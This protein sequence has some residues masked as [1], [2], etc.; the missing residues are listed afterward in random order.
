MKKCP[1]C[2]LN[3]ISNNE[4]LCKVCETK[5][6]NIKT[7]S[8]NTK[9]STNDHPF[10]FEGGNKLS[11]FGATWFVCYLYNKYIDNTFEIYKKVDTYKFR[12]AL[13]DACGKYY[14]IWL[15]EIIKMNDKKL[16]KNSLKIN[17]T[18]TKQMAQ[19]LLS[20]LV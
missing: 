5:N 9:N 13:C 8:K 16:N 1:I 10:S 20:V 7:S 2:E 4:T 3:Y 6:Y 19:K 17:S 14:K 12:M 11:K 18:Q 15:N